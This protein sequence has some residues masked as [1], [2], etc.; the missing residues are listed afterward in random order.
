[1][2]VSSGGIQWPTYALLD[3]GAN[4][5][6]ISK[7]L[8]DKLKAPVKTHKIKLG[9]FDHNSTQRREVASFEVS[10]LNESISIKIN[11]ALVGNLLST[12]GETPPS[13][14]DLKKFVH[15][16]DKALNDLEDK[17]VGLLLDA[18]HA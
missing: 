4:C 10:N 7:S 1:M 5:S 3:T 13:K 15:L 12:E 17:T 8:V 9:T 16:K 2:L 14:D 11:N 18:K 6:A